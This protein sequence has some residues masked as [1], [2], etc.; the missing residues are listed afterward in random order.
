MPLK[1]MG[2]KLVVGVSGRIHQY[3]CSAYET[4][5]QS[6]IPCL[7]GL[8]GFLL[9][10]L[11]FCSWLIPPVKGRVAWEASSIALL[12][13]RWLSDNLTETFHLPYSSLGVVAP[14]SS[15]PKCRV[16]DLAAT[17][18][19]T[20][21]LNMKE[22]SSILCPLHPVWCGLIR[23]L[24]ILGCLSAGWATKVAKQALGSLQKS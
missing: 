4:P 3:L 7:T 6:C 20:A 9:L 22:C 23:V 5:H 13:C 21:L 8:R 19:C 16:Y 15:F 14:T 12:P 11:Q 17:K 1:P 24:Q 10:P 18:E 2:I